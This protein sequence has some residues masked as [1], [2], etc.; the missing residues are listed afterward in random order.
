MLLLSISARGP[1]FNSPAAIPSAWIYDNSLIFNAPSKHIGKCRD[2][3][4]IYTSFDPFISF[5]TLSMCVSNS[6]T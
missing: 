4:R 3:P 1:C 2:L 6:S 5:A